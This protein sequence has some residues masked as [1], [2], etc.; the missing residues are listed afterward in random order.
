MNSLEIE[1]SLRNDPSTRDI[2]VGT[3]AADTLPPTKEFPGAYIANTQPS[4]QSG[5]H[6]VAFYCVSDSI[7]CFDSFGANPAVYS[8]HIKIWLDDEYKIIQKEVIQSNM[9]TVCGQYCMFFVLL[10]CNGFSYQDTLS[11]FTK[12]RSVN[13]RFVCKFINKYFML[14]KSVT[15]KKFLLDSLKRNGI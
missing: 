10:R 14:H 6:W 2:F 8:P 12:N 5:E 13:D 11:I 1:R 3:F 7:E 15:D 4:N 9:S